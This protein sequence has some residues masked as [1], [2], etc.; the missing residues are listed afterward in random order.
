MNE[1][2][3]S[4]RQ[5]NSLKQEIAAKADLIFHL[6]KLVRRTEDDLRESRIELTMSMHQ[7]DCV[8]AE[9]KQTET[10]LHLLEQTSQEQ[11]TEI[12]QLKDE[13][14]LLR[15]QIRSLQS[16]LTER[17]VLR[18][19]PEGAKSG[20]KRK[21]DQVQGDS[22]QIG[23]ECHVHCSNWVA[24]QRL[25][26]EKTTEIFSLRQKYESE[27]EAKQSKINEMLD[28]IKKLTLEVSAKEEVYVKKDRIIVQL[29]QQIKE[30]TECELLKQGQIADQLEEQEKQLS[31]NR[32][33][34]SELDDLNEKL[35]NEN[36]RLNSLRES[37]KEAVA[38][39]NEK[40][41][42]MK[43]DLMSQLKQKEVE[44]LR[45][46]SELQKVETRASFD[47]LNEVH[48][49]LRHVPKL[50]NMPGLPDQI[51]S[52]FSTLYASYE[53]AIEEVQLQKQQIEVMLREADHSNLLMYSKNQNVE[54]A[55]Q[56]IKELQ[57]Q[58]NAM[59][60]FGVN[61][62]Q[63]IQADQRVEIDRLKAIVQHLE[64]EKARN[65]ETIAELL[66]KP[67][68]PKTDEMIPTDGSTRQKIVS[69]AFLREKNVELIGSVTS[70]KEELK[71]QSTD[72]AAQIELLKE[73]IH[74][75]K[76]SV[77]NL[78][79]Q[80]TKL[81]TTLEKK[82]ET[83]EQLEKA[84][85]TATLEKE[86]LKSKSEQKSE[87][88]KKTVDSF[89]K[90]KKDVETLKSINANLESLNEVLVTQHKLA[91]E[92]EAKLTSKFE[93]RV[94]SLTSDLLTQQRNSQSLMPDQSVDDLK[95]I[96]NL[97][98][99][100][101]LCEKEKEQLKSELIKSMNT[102]DQLNQVHLECEMSASREKVLS[103]E[104]KRMKVMIV[105][106]KSKLFTGE[107][108]ENRGQ[109]RQL[110]D[111]L[112]ENDKRF[113]S[114]P[115]PQSS[116]AVPQLLQPPSLQPTSSSLQHPPPQETQ[117]FEQPQQPL[118]QFQSKSLQVQDAKPTTTSTT[119]ATK[120]EPAKCDLK[121]GTTP[122]SRCSK[123][124]I[125]RLKRN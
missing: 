15:D 84:L 111:L 87:Q 93:T 6:K 98:T 16:Q 104:L 10:R 123:F 95:Q 56:Q 99:Q 11:Q 108:K 119:L 78:T 73:E 83:V 77:L 118:H 89:K 62:A 67:Q 7:V 38:D 46:K 65:L 101:R 23:Q 28:E 71:K 39:L 41:L 53:A 96:L 19:M 106:M 69:N 91:K 59:A 76:M 58:L 88:L 64:D 34:L 75:L 82:D 29:T 12:H 81:T 22:D 48:D 51:Q 100:L 113:K 8:E 9:K 105:E 4:E 21:I 80:N 33:R 17:M 114:G 47:R 24:Q 31:L 18:S 26:D 14:E 121:D 13:N 42:K 1:T 79:S 92:H 70:L 50:L 52:T 102:Y 57:Q 55:Q 90:Q 109:K 117:Q 3:K 60:D 37:G 44:N 124:P 72:F 20:V 43:E 40:F 68:A 115:S 25:L 107:N 74:Q 112:D 54:H 49:D 103:S 32:Q 63:Q 110:S 5:L 97:Q 85:H 66:S 120:A 35:K 45:L 116:E 94:Q 61:T 125:R 122:D 36:D 30:I 2:F 86:T 27:L